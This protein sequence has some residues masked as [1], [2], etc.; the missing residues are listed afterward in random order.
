MESAA[1]AMWYPCVKVPLPS[2][3]APIITII[4]M[5]NNYCY[6]IT[7]ILGGCAHGRAAQVEAWSKATRPLGAS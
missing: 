3:A 2:T 5:H 1:S 6:I 4:I 7:I